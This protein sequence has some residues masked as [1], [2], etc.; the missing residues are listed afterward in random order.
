M[1]RS[2]R[3]PRRGVLLASLAALALA[4]CG[5]RAPIPMPAA[6]APLHERL[7]ALALSR[8]EFGALSLIPVRFVQSRV[9]GPFL[10][11]GR[12]LYCVSS[13]MRGRTFGRAERVKIVIEEKAGTLSVIDQDK[14]ACDFNRTEP[15]P[16]LETMAGAKS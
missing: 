8:P 4:G 2:C 13:R 7:A 16:E 9:S 15:L 11:E 12:T 14:E 6:S 10:D 1:S 5:V 3:L